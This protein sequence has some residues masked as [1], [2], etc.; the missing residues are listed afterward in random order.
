MQVRAM[1]KTPSSF[2]IVIANAHVGYGIM[3]RQRRKNLDADA[4]KNCSPRTEATFIRTG[5]EGCFRRS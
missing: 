1:R 4:V 2:I 3:S 5:I